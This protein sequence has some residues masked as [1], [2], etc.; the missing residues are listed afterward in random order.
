MAMNF[1][2][3]EGKYNGSTITVFGR[4]SVFDKVREMPVIGGKVLQKR[5][6]RKREK[7]SWWRE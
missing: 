4:N 1:A 5:E 3:L 6:E 7:W 2:I